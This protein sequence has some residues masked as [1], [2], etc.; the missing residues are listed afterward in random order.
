MSS[1]LFQSNPKFYKIRPALHHFRT[2]SQPT[3]WLVERHKS[4][5]RAGDDVFLLGGRF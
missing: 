3:T 4:R 5:I 2:A 1:W